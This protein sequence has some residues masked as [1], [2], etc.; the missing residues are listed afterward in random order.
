MALILGALPGSPT[1]LG[2]DSDGRI[3]GVSYDEMVGA[4]LR[5]LEEDERR[6]QDPA[7]VPSRAAE[8]AL[9]PPR[10]A[11][12]FSPSL[13]AHLLALALAVLL[14]A[15]AVGAAAA[16]QAVASYREA[17]EA[18]LQDTARAL[19]LALD[20]LLGADLAVLTALAAALALDADADPDARDALLRRTAAS[21]GTDIVLVDP[22]TGR[23]LVHTAVPPGAPTRITGMADAP[24][25]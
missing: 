15:L 21:T 7:V 13:R 11:V 22:A 1:L 6:R 24:R 17:F 4:A 3:V 19:A 18:R 8:G 23:Y 2:T 16:W 20:A 25:R 14:R 12:G 9:A 10:R 5:L